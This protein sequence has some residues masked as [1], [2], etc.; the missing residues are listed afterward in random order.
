[1][2]SKLIYGIEVM[3]NF[4][5]FFEL[6]AVPLLSRIRNFSFAVDLLPLQT[7]PGGKRLT[8]R[9]T[10]S[11]VVVVAVVVAEVFL[12]F[13]GHISKLTY[14]QNIIEILS[15]FVFFATFYLVIRKS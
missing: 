8:S 3:T 4:L 1:M 11:A 6:T 2:A 15:N 10:N 13:T 5:S 7:T 9:S 12:S 14:F